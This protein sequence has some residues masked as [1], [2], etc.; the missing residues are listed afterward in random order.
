MTPKQRLSAS[1]DLTLTYFQSYYTEWRL[2]KGLANKKLLEERYDFFSDI[3]NEVHKWD[4]QNGEATIA[5]EIKHGLYFDSIAQ[6]IQYVE[7]LF[8]LI[9]ASK[10]PDYF[11]SNIITYKAGEVTNAIKQF[12]ASHESI[13]RAFQ[14]PS[15]LLLNSE[16][17]ESDYNWGK[18]L[19]SKNVGGPGEFLQ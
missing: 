5:Q 13:S 17:D 10:K 14:F 19:A 8:A 6:C 12:K 11:I 3:S 2:T 9:R 1:I 4:D 18:D 16:E 7:D 15:E